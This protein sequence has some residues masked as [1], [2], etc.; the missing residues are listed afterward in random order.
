MNPS[1]NPNELELGTLLTMSH[2]ALCHGRAR[3]G[4]HGLPARSLALKPREWQDVEGDFFSDSL[5]PHRSSLCGVGEWPGSYSA[6]WRPTERVSARATLVQV[7]SGGPERGFRDPMGAVNSLQR[8]TAIL[9]KCRIE[10][11]VALRILE[12]GTNW[13]IE[14]GYFARLA[15]ALTPFIEHTQNFDFGSL[16]R[17]WVRDGETFRVLSQLAME[18]FQA[19]CDAEERAPTYSDWV[20]LRLAIDPNASMHFVPDR[21][22]VPFEDDPDEDDDSRRFSAVARMGLLGVEV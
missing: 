7:Q 13:T 19:R 15:Q 12:L 20:D 6:L 2:K 9:Q 10:L 11:G 17:E 21:Y 8:L 1:V 14:S 22:L 5:L 3:G 4:G 18:L 16:H